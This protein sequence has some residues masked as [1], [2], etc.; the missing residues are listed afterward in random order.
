MATQ[1][2]LPGITIHNGA[3]ASERA[4]YPHPSQQDSVECSTRYE[5]YEQMWA[6]YTNSA[7]DDLEAWRRYKSKYNLYEF[8]RGI[9]NPVARIVDFYA[10]NIYPGVIFQ[11]GTQ[12][13]DVQTAIPLD[14]TADNKVKEAIYQLWDW[15]NWQD[16]QSLFVLY[17]ALTGNSFVEV[18]EDTGRVYLQPHWSGHVKEI[19]LDPVGDVT[20]YVLEYDV[21]DRIRREKYCYRKVV[22]PESIQVYIDDARVED[23]I[24]PYPFVPGVWC[25]HI[26]IG[27]DYGVPAI[28]SGLATIDELN[29]MVSHTSD[30][31]HKQIHSPRVMWTDS[32]L[33]PLFGNQMKEIDQIDQ[34]RQMVLLKGKAGGNTETLVGSLDPATIVPLVDKMLQE[35]ERLYPEI[36]FYEKLRDQSI[37]TSVGAKAL[38]G[39]VS[40]KVSRPA[41]NYDR[42]STRLFAMGLA[43]AG[44]RV[45]DGSWNAFAP[46]T[47]QQKKYDGFGYDSYNAGELNVK[48]LPRSIV[49][50][51]S[52]EQAEELELRA[53]AIAQ[54]EDV[55]SQEEKLKILG[56]RDDEI[57]E[58]IAKTKVEVEEKQK[59]ETE[60]IEVQ[61]KAKADAK[62]APTSKP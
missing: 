24:N 30:H 59:R 49:P 61:S 27:N 14:P 11:Y 51:T 60:L 18:V 37:V 34:R 46:L 38:M 42:A 25:K 55:I 36:V 45:R 58:I 31:V 48:I 32:T 10:E 2:W 50:E 16:L 9:F 33:T 35:L 39:D 56:Y 57:E 22:L 62:P 47:K 44:E 53:R 52:R 3:P 41:A 54:I 6:Y 13:K 17:G 19:N 29:S 7:F 20:G 12:L 43:I 26:N 15:G 8:T 5:A 23:R 4:I 40:K 1:L 28:K 21:I